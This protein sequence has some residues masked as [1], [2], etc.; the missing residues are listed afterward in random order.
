MDRA[1]KLG[2]FTTTPRAIAISGLAAGIG[3][4]S[5]YVAWALLKLIGIFTNL[6]F[7][8]RWSISRRRRRR[9]AWGPGRCSC[10]W[11]AL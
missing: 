2:D 3:L 5:S 1:E 4:V 10:R 8:H 11:W 7:F 9:I 6:F